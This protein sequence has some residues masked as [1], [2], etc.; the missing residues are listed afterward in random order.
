MG[1]AA[2]LPPDMDMF[3]IRGR[4]Q[5]YTPYIIVS[6]QE[7][8]RMNVLLQAIRSSLTELELGISGALNVSDGMELLSKNLQSNKVN[9][10][11]EKFAYPSLKGLSSWFADLVLRV[12]QLVKWTT[13]LSLL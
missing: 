3:E 10:K 9:P 4:I 5:E 11:W 2:L 12:D 7:S 6:L 8:E 13:A 1:Y